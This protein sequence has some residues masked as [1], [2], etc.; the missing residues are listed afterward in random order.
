MGVGGLRMI[1]IET[2]HKQSFKNRLIL[3]IHKRCGCFFCMESFYLKEVKEWT[4]DG[5]TALCPNCDMDSVLPDDGTL[6]LNDLMAMHHRWFCT[7]T[8]MKTDKEISI[9]DCD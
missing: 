6:T 1:D 5:Q 2:F 3:G 4:D 7:A 9:C 8:N